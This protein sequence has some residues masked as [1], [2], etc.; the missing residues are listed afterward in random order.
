MVV[1]ISGD[2]WG[3]VEALAERR[4]TSFSAVVRQALTEHLM[5]S[6]VENINAQI[7]QNTKELENGP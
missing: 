7:R 3:Y 4:A 6:A 5:L 2:L 1:R